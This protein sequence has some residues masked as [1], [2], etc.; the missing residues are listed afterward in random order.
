MIT[1]VFADNYKC[2]VNFEIRLGP[3]NLVLGSNGSGKT[4]L[5]EVL[6]LLHRFIAG[7]AQTADLWPSSTLTR[8]DLRSVQ[9]F[10]IDVAANNGLFSYRLELEQD[11]QRRRCRLKSER[12]LFDGNPLYESSND[13][14]QL[15]RD[16]Y[17]PGPRVLCDWHRSGLAIIQA[18]HDN[19]KLTCFKQ[20]ICE[21]SVVRIDPHAMGAISLEEEAYPNADLSNF[22]SWF[23]HLSQDQQGQVFN[24]TNVLRDE[25]LEGFDSF[26]LAASADNSRVLSVLFR[27]DQGASTSNEAIEFRFD[28]LSDGQRALI[29]L[30]TVIHC[31]ADHGRTLCLD[32]PECALALPEIQPWLLKL[33]DLVE[34]GQVQAVLISHHPDLVNLLASHNGYWFERSAC[35]PTRVRRISDEEPSELTPAELVA[36]G[37][38]HA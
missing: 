11:R 19:T 15:Y 30:N 12:L 13:N 4:T 16:D 2:L 5:F 38:L 32:Q 21:C 35:G 17:T 23:R 3:L 8:W 24:L 20:R 36:R 25:V 9:T 31:F 33:V 6:S 10:E 22:A 18:R 29:A 14:A 26:R 28:E 37:W 27:R 7:D 34:D 1:R